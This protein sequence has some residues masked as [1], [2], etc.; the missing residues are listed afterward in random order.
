VPPCLEYVHFCPPPCKRYARASVALTSSL[1]KIAAPLA[2]VFSA[3]SVFAQVN[4]L[5]NVIN[6]RSSGQQSQT[7]QHYG[8]LRLDGT[9]ASLPSLDIYNN[10]TGN[11]T[12]YGVRAIAA[13]AANYGTGGQFT[14]GKMGINA[15]ATTSG[16]GFRYGGY[17]Q[18]TNGNNTNYGLYATASGPSGSVNYGV[19]ASASGGTTNYAGYFTGPIYV[20]GTIYPSDKR[21][22]LNQRKLE[23][24]LSKIMALQPENYEYDTA[25]YKAMN[26]P[27]GMQDGLI[28]QDVETVMPELVTEV[29]APHPD[30]DTVDAAPTTPTTFKAINYNGFIAVLIAAVQEQEKRIAQQEKRIQQ[31]E[32]GG[33]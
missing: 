26:L 27:T 28:A 10:T 20:A 1:R 4:I 24:A 11:A 19:Y 17:L 21:L 31:L 6:F 30:I 3:S 16:S 25:T 18:G 15:S 5:A 9:A 12:N 2:I 8:N 29:T 33:R 23:N 32:S 22:K 13:P 14:G 7:S